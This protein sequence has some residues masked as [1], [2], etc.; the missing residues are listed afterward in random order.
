MGV[1][2][3]ETKQSRCCAGEEPGIMPR[4]TQVRT[5]RSNQK[6]LLGPMAA[7]S[8][9]HPPRAWGQGVQGPGRVAS[10]LHC[11]QQ[12]QQQQRTSGLHQAWLSGCSCILL[13]LGPIWPS[14]R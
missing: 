1:K 12:Q 6:R 10:P 11:M 9:R 13:C 5:Y 4:Y 2:E 3:H 14:I 7:A 8:S